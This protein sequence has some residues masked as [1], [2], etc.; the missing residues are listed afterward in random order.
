[1]CNFDHYNFETNK[2]IIFCKLLTQVPVGLSIAVTFISAFTVI[3]F[4][5]EAYGYGS[6]LVWFAFVTI[7]PN[8]IACIYYIPLIHRLGLSSIYEV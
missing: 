3:G 1:M 7:V 5:A 4:P 6:V 2:T 8:I